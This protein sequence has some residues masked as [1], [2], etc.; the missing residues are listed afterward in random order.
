LA[1]AP[2]CQLG[3]DCCEGGCANL[4]NDIHNCGACGVVCG[5][6]SP[7]CDGTHCVQAPCMSAQDC[8]DTC[9]GTTC[10][11]AGQLCCDVQGP[12]PTQGPKCT[13]P[14]NGTCPLGCPTCD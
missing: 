6:P 14:V 5:G 4:A 13:D 1:C 2:A 8:T 7:F 12:G 10:C 9:C 3:F 11:G